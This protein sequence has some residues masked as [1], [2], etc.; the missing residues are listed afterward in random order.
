MGAHDSIITP[1]LCQPCR[2]LLIMSKHSSM[3]LLLQ[4]PSAH[5]VNGNSLQVLQVLLQALLIQLQLRIQSALQQDLHIV[6]LCVFSSQYSQC[7]MLARP[8]AV[9]VH[10]ITCLKSLGVS[11]RQ[12]PAAC[13][14][15]A[16]TRRCHTTSADAKRFA[17]TPETQNAGNTIVQM[18]L[19]CD[20]KPQCLHQ[21]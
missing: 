10:R 12:S 2:G 18:H 19:G 13:R 7:T 8:Q 20:W 17:C 6:M 1:S 21:S 16:A 5:E 15:E 4:R 14:H 11:W 3:L 9:A